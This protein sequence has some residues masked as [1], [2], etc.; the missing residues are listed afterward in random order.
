MILGIVGPQWEQRIVA[1]LD[2]SLNKWIDSV[3]DHRTRPTPPGSL[4]L[5]YPL[6]VR[7]DPNREN[8]LFFNQS[9]TLFTN[10]YFVQILIHRPFISPPSKPS[11]M[12]F[13][14]LAICTNAA[15]SCCH[16]ADIQNQRGAC[17]LG[18]IQVRPRTV[19]SATI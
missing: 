16:V 17:P 8:L 5:T 2:S 11:S 1:E 9:A 13:P 19:P 6:L 18:Y 7:W 10:Y 4:S 14:S 3:P 15:R 12:T